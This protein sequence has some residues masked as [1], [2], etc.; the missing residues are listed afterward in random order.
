MVLS[1]FKLKSVILI[2]FVLEL[3]GFVVEVLLPHSDVLP[4]HLYLC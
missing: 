2:A 4:Y 1:I 3:L